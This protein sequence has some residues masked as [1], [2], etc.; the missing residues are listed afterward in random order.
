MNIGKTLTGRQLFRPLLP[1]QIRKIS[2]FSSARR[3]RKGALIYGPDTEARHVFILLEG[4][5]HLRLPGAAGADGLVLGPIGRDELFGIAPLVGTSRYTTTAKCA[6]ASRIL[7]IE[8]RPLV[9]LLRANPLVGQQVMTVVARSY[10][11]RFQLVAERIQKV[12]AA[13]AFTE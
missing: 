2:G 10:H 12:L 7:F 1:E 6:K 11:D 4:E 5:V 9:E 3:F 8:A 13:V